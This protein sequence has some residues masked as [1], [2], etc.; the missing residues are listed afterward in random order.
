MVFVFIIIDISITFNGTELIEPFFL[1]FFF[2]VLF[3]YGEH[4]YGSLNTSIAQHFSV[5]KKKKMRYTLVGI[6]CGQ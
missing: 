1:F 2:F 5:K 3:Q 6:K 4:F